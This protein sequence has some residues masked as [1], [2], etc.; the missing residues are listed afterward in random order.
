[1]STQDMDTL[2][3]QVLDKARRLRRKAWNRIWQLPLAVAYGFIDLSVDSDVRLDNTPFGSLWHRDGMYVPSS[4]FAFT[5]NDEL[6]KSLTVVTDSYVPSET[7]P[8][9]LVN[10]YNKAKLEFMMRHNNLVIQLCDADIDEYNPQVCI[11]VDVVYGEPDSEEYT[12]DNEP[13][14]LD[15]PQGYEPV[16]PYK[17]RLT[18]RFAD[19]VVSQDE[20]P[21]EFYAGM[22][23]E[24]YIHIRLV[25]GRMALLARDSAG[26]EGYVA[27]NGLAVEIVNNTNSNILVN[28]PPFARFS[29]PPYGYVLMVQSASWTMLYRIQ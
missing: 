28:I 12:I 7:A 3:R 22:T 4:T 14:Y 23:E 10:E 11:N 13:T 26:A 19:R 17:I 8:E 15:Y 21:Q 2:Y 27:D 9:R 25:R 18:G 6:L 1:M 24:A 29:L 16:M 5:K 20:M